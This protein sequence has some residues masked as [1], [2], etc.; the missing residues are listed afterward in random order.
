MYVPKHLEARSNYFFLKQVLN[1]NRT[2]RKD[3]RNDVKILITTDLYKPLINGVV[4][5]VINLK[6]GLEDQG[7]EVRIL[8]LSRTVQSAEKEGVYYIG[9]INV[10]DV[11]PG[12]R[13]SLK[14]PAAMYKSI[15]SWKPDVVH[16]QC[17]LSTFR[18]ARKISE[19]CGVPFVHTY[20]TLYENY[21]HYLPVL[22]RFCGLLVPKL[23][24]VVL[25]RTD[26]VIAPTSKVK[27]ILGKYGISSPVSV[28]MSGVDYQKLARKPSDDWIVQKKKVL[29]INRNS[30]C[31]ICVGRL[32]K[33]KR[34]DELLRLV[35]KC[36]DM[37][38]KL[39]LV[40]DGPDKNRLKRLCERLH[41]ADRVAFTGM[42]SPKDIWM[43]YH[44]GDVFVNASE[45]ETQ[46]LSNAEAMAAGLPMLCRR[47]ECLDQMIQDGVNGWQYR[48]SCEFRDY[49]KKLLLDDALRKRM[50]LNSMMKAQQLSIANFANEVI[51]CYA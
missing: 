20:H 32:A 31:L 18:Y 38:I 5:S 35:A 37:P 36:K 3:K 15:I 22:G 7:H 29:R 21:T 28:V 40:G 24:T 13:I 34:V 44:L 12:A 19:A 27:R 41:I 48:N 2:G 46:G 23:T 39:V 43:Y 8:T 17:E 11:Y 16:S 45:S 1:V 25:R 51:N 9:S 10:G 4:T 26:R 49:L 14:M 47:D 6:Q 33:E 42:I 50:S 30:L